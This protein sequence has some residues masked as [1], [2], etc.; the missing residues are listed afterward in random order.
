M[1]L[2]RSPR[3]DFFDWLI[4][5]NSNSIVGIGNIT[6]PH[7]THARL[8]PTQY[9]LD[10][11]RNATI[12]RTAATYIAIELTE[13]GLVAAGART[14]SCGQRGRFDD[15]V[16]SI[17]FHGRTFGRR[18]REDALRAEVTHSMHGLCCELLSTTRA[19]IDADS[20]MHEPN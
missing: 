19:R 11:K 2:C 3:A 17:R 9:I 1:R 18:R 8:S 13:T 14:S 5:A 16:C 6:H 10:D 15:D 7:D 20:S 4:D 12:D